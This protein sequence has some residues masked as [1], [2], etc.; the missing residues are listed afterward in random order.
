MI[1]D[2][3]VQTKYKSEIEKELQ[4]GKSTDWKAI[5][6]IITNS[7]QKHLG[8]AKKV[9]PNRR[10]HD[11]DIQE[12]SEKQKQLRLNLSRC[13]DVTEYKAMK[14]ERNK[15]LHEIKQRLEQDKEQ[16]LYQK[17]SQLDQIEDASKMYKS[18]KILQQKS[19]AN[20]YVHDE[21]KKCITKP[22]EIYKVVREHFEKHFNDDDVSSMKPYDG[23]PRKLNKEISTEEVRAGI[24]KLNNNKTPGI[25]NISAEMVKY[26]PLILFETIKEIFNEAFEKEI[27]LELG[28]SI[29]PYRNLA[30]PKVLLPTCDQ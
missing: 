17:V 11:Q 7:A 4:Q 29:L 3:N 8:H 5:K 19:F 12:M 2:E 18:V 24:N 9:G 6:E 26:G 22:S 30:K 28:E 20:P 25:D 27:E 1:K 21:N 23:Q 10:T 13:H 14:K 15:I 16:E